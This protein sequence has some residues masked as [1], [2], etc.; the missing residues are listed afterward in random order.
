[1][2]D[3]ERLE[4]LE[5]DVK[6][7]RES[8]GRWI[9]ENAEMKQKIASLTRKDDA[10]RVGLTNRMDR[11]EKKQDICIKILKQLAKRP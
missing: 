1:M 5:A 3:S 2:N 6:Q 7:L 8:E 9:R 10:T 11:M 4:L